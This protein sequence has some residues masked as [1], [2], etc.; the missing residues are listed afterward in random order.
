MTKNK[1]NMYYDISRLF[2][3]FSYFILFFNNL[4]YEIINYQPPMAY[5]LSW[6]GYEVY[7]LYSSMVG[8]SLS[9]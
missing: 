5:I 7:Y 9:V 8:I 6:I 1:L 4:S 3:K 2:I